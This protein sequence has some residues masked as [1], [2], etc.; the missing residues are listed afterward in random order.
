MPRTVA[1]A[2]NPRALARDTA[3]GARHASPHSLD[4]SRQAPMTSAGIPAR[5][6]GG[7]DAVHRRLDL[8][9]GG[10]DLGNQLPPQ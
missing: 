4:A 3:E 1:L 6:R 2:P 5:R 8:T 9:D 10:E 7:A